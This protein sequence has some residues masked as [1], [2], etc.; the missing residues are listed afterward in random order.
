[1]GTSVP[2]TH[3]SNAMTG[4]AVSSTAHRTQSFAPATFSPQANTVRNTTP[5]HT[6]GSV[7]G[8]CPRTACGTPNAAISGR[9]GLYWL[10]SVVAASAPALRYG[11]PSLI[12]VLAELVTT[13]TSG[14]PWPVQISHSSGTRMA[15]QTMMAS[16][17]SIPVVPR[18]RHAMTVSA[19]SA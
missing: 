12:S 14:S 3:S 11:V 19:A 7:S 9:Y 8:P 5:N 2:P 17:T 13:P 15:P 4:D 6:R 10:G 1:M 16:A 18:D